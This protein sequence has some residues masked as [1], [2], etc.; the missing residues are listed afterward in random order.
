MIVLIGFIATY[1][2]MRDAYI[3]VWC[4]FAA[5]ASIVVYVHVSDVRRGLTRA[6]NAASSKRPFGL[7]IVS[8][9]GCRTDSV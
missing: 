4:F 1:F 8:A 3:S 7:S 6:D 5:L 9:P 2:L